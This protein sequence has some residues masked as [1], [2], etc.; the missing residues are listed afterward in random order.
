MRKLL[1][2]LFIACFAGCNISNSTPP[3]FEEANTKIISDSAGIFHGNSESAK[4]MAK[5]FSETMKVLQAELF[6][7]GKKNRIISLTGEEFL[8]FCKSDDRFVVFLVHVP[9]L[10]RYKGEVR[11]A[12]LELA[13][14][15]ANNATS[16]HPAGDNLEIAIGLRGS[17]FYGG[18]A[19]G[20]KGG[21]PEYENA[22]TIDKEI[23]YKYFESPEEE[24]SSDSTS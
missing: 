2:L 23:F 21:E 16:G 22:A 14:V 12:L 5:Q 13:W 7:G 1:L 3:E 10:K 9:Q 11:D 6:T 18:S 4:E 8:T 15:V 17:F 24:S 19:I 20:T